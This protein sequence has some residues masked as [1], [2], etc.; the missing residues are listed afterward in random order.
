MYW[1]YFNAD[2]S[3]AYCSENG[4]L[5]PSEV[6][7]LGDGIKEVFVEFKPEL[8]EG[9]EDEHEDVWLLDDGTIGLKL[10]EVRVGTK[11]YI[12]EAIDIISMYA[13]LDELDRPDSFEYHK[14]LLEPYVP[15]EVMDR[16]LEDKLISD[17]EKQELY[18]LCNAI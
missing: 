14:E 18:K 6:E 12:R 11:R 13:P 15:K 16:I 1:Y 2:N 4:R 9:S 3:H 7:K 17:A 8:P 10:D 5:S